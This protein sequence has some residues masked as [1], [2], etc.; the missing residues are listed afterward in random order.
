MTLCRCTEKGQHI[1]PPSDVQAPDQTPAS[2][3]SMNADLT[4][5]VSQTPESVK[6]KCSVSEKSPT[7]SA[8]G[9]DIDG[10]N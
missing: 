4:D 10:E 9:V 6:S 8:P 1:S 3:L 7:E 2:E 5:S